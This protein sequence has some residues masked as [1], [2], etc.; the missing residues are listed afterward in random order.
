MQDA[1][2]HTMVDAS[3]AMPE[4]L[5]GIRKSDE[6][7]DGISGHKAY[8]RALQA[9]ADAKYAGALILYTTTNLP[10]TE[11]AAKCG[12]K[13]SAFRS[14]M[15]RRHR[16]L[17][18]ARHGIDVGNCDLRFVKIYPPKGQRPATYLKY[19]DAVEACDSMSYIEY[20]ISQIARMFGLNGTQLANQLRVHY[21]DIPIFREKVRK[22]LGL[23]DNVHHGVRPYCAKQYGD[24]VDMYLNTDKTVEQV[25]DECGVSFRGLDQHLRFYHKDVINRKEQRRKK[26]KGSRKRGTLIGNGQIKMPRNGSEDKYSRAVLLADT[27]DMSLEEIAKKMGLNKNSLRYHLRTW[28]KDILGKRRCITTDGDAEDVDLGGAKHY[29]RSTASKYAPAIAW[30]KDNPDKA[31]AEAAAKYGFNPEVFRDYLKEHEPELA[32]SRGMTRRA[33]GKLVRR[34]SEEKYAAA[35][36][37]YATTTEPLKSIARRY[38]IVYNSIMGYVIRNCPDERERH[39]RLVAEME[40]RNADATG[41]ADA[42]TNTNDITTA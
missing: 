26:A 33:N 22:R 42:E 6:N 4:S 8:S 15:L 11:I 36:H 27:T 1:Y 30:L 37:E 3:M 25:A 14:W 20:N 29:L 40:A 16:D 34:R 2:E 18:M 10:C 12:V 28:H 24:A 19:K 41:T 35:I 39:N 23:A 17:V 5:T 9:E 21:P 38:G 7:V 13:A 32:A 31:V